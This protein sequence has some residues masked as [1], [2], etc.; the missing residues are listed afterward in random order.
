MNMRS[1]SCISEAKAAVKH[2]DQALMRT[3]V[4]GI[5]TKSPL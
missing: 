3:S 5:D 4:V 2:S 1:D